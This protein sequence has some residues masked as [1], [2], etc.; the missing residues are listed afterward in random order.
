M[1]RRLTQNDFISKAKEIHK[2]KYDYSEVHYVNSRTKVCIICPEHGEFWQTPSTHLKGCGCPKCSG[3]FLDKDFFIEKANKIHKNKYDYSKVTYK[4]NKTK[5]EIICPIHGSFW[6]TPNDHLDR[7]GCP[8]CRK[9]KKLTTTTFIERANKIHNFRYDY[10]KVNYVNADSK[11]EIICKKHGSFFQ[12]PS[13]HIAGQGCPKCRLK[14]QSKLYERLKNALPGIEIIY[15]ADKIEWLKP[16]R[17]D[18]YFPKYNIAVEY[19]GIQHYQAVQNWGGELYFQRQIEW[20]KRKREKSKI[21]NCNLFEIKYN[22][23]NSDFDIL[24]TNIKTIIYG[25]S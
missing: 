10:S 20:D 5:V 16:Q 14:E 2:N 22:Y 9:S 3:K 21:N 15:E 13:N 18:I 12:L 17:F 8:E 7:C 25:T 6:Q 1:A 11:V 24:L 4:G 23:T 19:N